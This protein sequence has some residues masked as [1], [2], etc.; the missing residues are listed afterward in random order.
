MEREN[1]Y[2]LLELKSDPP[3]TNPEVIEKA[4]AKKQ[5]EWSRLRNH[6]TKGLHAQKYINMIP[7]IR[8]VM[9]DDSL[10]AKEAEAARE[11]LAKN[12][13]SKYPEIDRHIDILMGKGHI[14]GEEKSRLAKVHGLAES[15]IQNRINSR[16]NEKYRRIDQQITLRMAKGYLTE[17]EVGKIAKR[18]SAKYEE[19]LQR[20]RCPV[21]KTEKS[22]EAAAPRQLDRSLEKTIQD[23]L[24]LLNK[25]SLYEFLGLPE[26][27]DLKNLQ[28]AAIRKKKELTQ[29]S[30]K[31][32]AGTASNTLAG[33]CIT[34]F[35]SE[36]NRIAY[37]VSLARTKLAALDSDIDIA[38][39][40]GKL[41]PEYFEILVSKAMDFGMEKDE[42]V[43][44]IKDYCRR[45]KLTIEMPPD[46]RRKYRIAAA[47]AAAIILILAVSGGL[48]YL[49]H[50][51][52]AIEQSFAELTEQINSTT[53]AKEK[54]RL[55]Q[56]FINSHGGDENYESYIKQA[57]N[58][59]ADIKENISQQ[60][61]RNLT[62]KADEL[63]AEEKFSEAKAEYRKYL[64][65]NPPDKYAKKAEAQIEKLS[66]QIET[67]DFENL[68][69][70]M[71]EG[72]APEKID[73]ITQYT[74]DHPEGE[75]KKD[76]R[77][78][79]SEISSEYY[80][81]ITKRLETLE[82][83]KD[84][85]QCAQLCENY[86]SLYDN[87]YADQLKARL[88][89]YREKITQDK[90]FSA[91][92]RKAENFGSDYSSAIEIYED[93]ITAYPDTPIAGRIENE[94]GN[95]KQ[96]Q[97][98]KALEDAR[99]KFRI[100]V[101]QAGGRFTEKTEGVVLDRKTG[102][103][104]QLLDTGLSNPGQCFDYEKAKE[105]VENLS[106]DGYSD[107]R[108]PRPEELTGIY[109]TSPYF[110]AMENK[111]Y[112]SAE[113]YFRYSD[114]SRESR[115]I[116]DTVDN[117]PSATPGVRRRDSGECGTV[118]AVHD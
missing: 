21:V 41:R 86:I 3:E 13:E 71:I 113:S 74:R 105:Y 85:Q 68:T 90:K 117:T 46:K 50:R 20:V 95:L 56:T 116:V 39:I 29:S 91:L 110:P 18:N 40:N 73:A 35:K 55:L 12:R 59:L 8:R 9:K 83:E 25:S 38:G 65:K 77:K 64:G 53:D 54:I 109:K 72:T 42:A 70:I 37:D 98:E 4:I 107:W 1:F 67:R 100:M 104:W 31:D 47:A 15:E 17:S 103:M 7:E 19:V 49:G 115:R 44:Y 34:I 32:A 52:K 118:R 89:D 101:K 99:E 81:Y 82:K 48:L 88:E 111:W 24:K 114:D 36:A 33:H 75:H 57:E 78:M 26:S 112:W 66:G 5:S 11:L 43:R 2:I 51:Q 30:K 93:Y 45:K 87:S 14:T 22:P 27:A 10:R 61:Y 60:D 97:R 23:N 79:L 16:K 63:T 58:R 108:L 6:P 69:Q 96:K 80:V 76:A 102:L 92:R 62:T 106:I 94:I 28:E 84:W